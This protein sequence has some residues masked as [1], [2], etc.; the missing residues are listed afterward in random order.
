MVLFEGTN[1]LCFG[2]FSQQ[3]SLDCTLSVTSYTSLS[4]S[5]DLVSEDKVCD[6]TKRH[7]EDA[8]HDKVQVELC[9]L[10]IQLLQN[11]F[12]LLEVACLVFVAVQVLTV[13]PVYGQ[14]DSFKTIS[15]SQ[16]TADLEKDHLRYPIFLVYSFALLYSS[17]EYL[18]LIGQMQH[19][20]VK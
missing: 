4:L 10:D 7:K 19:S 5:T 16:R 12:W 1:P 6:E 18:F 8:Q 17:M 2:F 3:E 20:V 15:E 14:N 9:I 11:G 13:E